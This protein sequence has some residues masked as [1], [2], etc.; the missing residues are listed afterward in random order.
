MSALTITA[1]DGSGSLTLDD[2][3]LPAQGIDFGAKTRLVQTYYPGTS[4][5]STQ[6]MGTQEEPILLRGVWRDEWL[7]LL[8]GAYEL[9]QEARALLLGQARCELQWGSL[10]RRGYVASFTATLRRLGYWDW[11]LTFNVDQADEALVISLPIPPAATPFSLANLL[12]AALQAA[13]ELA[14]VAV[15]ANNF[16]QA[17]A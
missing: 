6:I 7:G 9:V 3:A 14:T 12:A 11:S 5:P 8:D 10:T 13:D 4:S 15:A 1:L 16:L 17:V 2:S